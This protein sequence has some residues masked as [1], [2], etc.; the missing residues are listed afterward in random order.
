MYCI[1]AKDAL[2]DFRNPH[3]T[4]QAVKIEE[5]A[6]ITHRY[7]MLHYHAT[8]FEVLGLKH[9][10]LRS[11][12]PLSIAPSPEAI[13]KIEEWEATENYKLPA[14]VREWYSF[15]GWE[16]LLTPPGE[17]C[18]PCTLDV[19]LGECSKAL[20]TNVELDKGW[21]FF[22]GPRRA[23]TG[24]E[25]YLILDGSD[26]PKVA[27]VPEA[28]ETNDVNRDVFSEYIV[29]LCWA[30][31]MVGLPYLKIMDDEVPESVILFLQDKFKELPHVKQFMWQKPS[32]RCFIM[33]RTRV[34]MEKG[35]LY[36][37]AETE[38]ELLDAY[39]EFLGRMNNP[40]VEL[41]KQV[42]PK[43]FTQ[44]FPDAKWKDLTPSLQP[45]KKQGFWHRFFGN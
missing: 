4:R 32:N 9:G 18:E 41:S 12:S 43:P 45:A 23:N 21:V 16:K 39:V 31:R 20:Q 5:S 22:Y 2:H 3:P 19:F 6:K 38:E 8:A 37:V 44:R 34:E 24:Y 25:V 42:N 13:R 1:I 15:E 17:D 14:S 28:E 7:T 33:G 11:K 27:E 30:Y 40:S 26:D 10:F 35:S 36:V 29:H